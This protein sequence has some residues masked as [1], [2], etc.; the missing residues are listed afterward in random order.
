MDSPAKGMSKHIHKHDRKL[1][2]F[3]EQVVWTYASLYDLTI[4][5]VKPVKRKNAGN[6]FGQCSKHGIVRLTLRDFSHGHWARRPELAYEIV[7]TIA[8][9]LAHLRHQKHDSAWLKLYAN[10]LAGLSSTKVLQKIKRL[11]K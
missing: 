5:D 1:W 10:I 4:S 11:R 7:D 8:H 3:C 2:S 6:R 9:E